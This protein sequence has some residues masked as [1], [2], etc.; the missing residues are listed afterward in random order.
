M[1]NRRFRVDEPSDLLVRFALPLMKS[2]GEEPA[3]RALVSTQKTQG[4][5]DEPV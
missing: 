2:R 1:E 3:D 4:Y 5:D